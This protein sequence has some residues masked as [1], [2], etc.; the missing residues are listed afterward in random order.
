[1][2]KLIQIWPIFGNLV[3]IVSIN[4]WTSILLLNILAKIREN[5]LT[6]WCTEKRKILF[7]AQIF[8]RVPYFSYGLLDRTHIA[9]YYC[10]QGKALLLIPNGRYH[11]R[12]KYLMT[13]EHHL[14]WELNDDNVRS[15]HFSKINHF[16]YHHF[17]IKKGLINPITGHVSSPLT[18]SLTPICDV[19]MTSRA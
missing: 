2:A 3:A 10:D 19:K 8:K 18:I 15:H 14:H 9:S 7:I 5:L 4:I 11:H 16:F 6:K 12:Y 1:M 17:T 13:F